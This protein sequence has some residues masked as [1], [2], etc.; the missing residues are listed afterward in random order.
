MAVIIIVTAGI[1]LLRTPLGALRDPSQPV[2]VARNTPPPPVE[3]PGAVLNLESGTR[4]A[5]DEKGRGL[6]RLPR[7]RVS[8]RI[9]LPLGLEEGHYEVTLDR[10]STPPLLQ[11]VSDARME[12]GLAVLRIQPDFSGFAAGQ[13]RLRY[14]RGDESWRE[15][16]I[17]LE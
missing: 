11:L 14:R 12:D 10:G 2:P 3:L 8:L 1:L 17:L 7:K 6:Q 9:Y 13:Y 5:Q 4:G 16:T 15:A